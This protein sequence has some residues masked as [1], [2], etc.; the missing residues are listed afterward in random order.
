MHLDGL[1]RLPCTRGIRNLIADG[2]LARS[3]ASIAATL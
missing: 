1:V 3:A 2:Q